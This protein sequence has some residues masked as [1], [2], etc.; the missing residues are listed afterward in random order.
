MAH[1]F[2]LSLYAATQRREPGAPDPRP[3]PAGALVWVHA[4]TVDAARPLTE[5]ARRLA[6][7]QD[8]TVLMTGAEGPPPP[9]K[10]V[11]RADLP[12]EGRAQIRAFLDHWRPDLGLWMEGDLR[13]ALLADAAAR[14]IPLIF[15]DAQHARLPD[16][17]RWFPGLTR[18][19][20]GHF[21]HILT[22][23]D[24]ASRA[25]LRAG[26]D[27]GRVKVAGR[28]EEPH[29]TLPCTEAERAELARTIGARPVW[30]AA[31]LP[32]V[33]EDAVIAAHRSAL[34]LSHRLLLIVMP[35]SADR[36]AELARRMEAAGLS[37]AQRA[38]EDDIHPETEVYIADHPDELGLW[39]RLASICYAGGSLTTGARRDPLEAAALG[40]A[41][42]HGPKAGIY[43]A[44]FARLA[45]RG[46]TLPV[47]QAKGLG[48][49]LADLMSPER[50]AAL[51]G[52]AW[53][54]ASDGSEVTDR[55]LDLIDRM[56]EERA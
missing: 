42:I 44:P 21:A 32:Q 4:P 26:A 1:S 25:F 35:E 10:G 8:R 11:L 29:L 2:G 5:L 38:Q 49:A 7:E 23:D 22:L 13:P 55:V 3:R 48:D 6:E 19:T 30:L 56:I 16:R 45:A 9:P 50:V 34:R 31:C 54:M 18:A 43:A 51:A 37:V 36:A 40:S 12:G 17:A 46:A 15:A 20:M 52:A 14:G 27:E 28:M 47:T 33:E 24:A 53:D 39:Y 41:L